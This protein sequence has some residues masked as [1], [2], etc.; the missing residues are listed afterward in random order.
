VARNKHPEETVRRILEI[1][2]QLFYKKGFE[3]TS[4][5]D[6]VNALGMSKGAIYHHFKSKE[7][8]LERI[9]DTFKGEEEWYHRILNDHSLTGLQKL[10]YFFYY[11][12]SNE[13]KQHR[14]QLYLLNIRDPQ[15]IAMSLEN[16]MNT[17]SVYLSAFLEEGRRDGSMSVKHPYETAQ[18][19]LLLCNF[20]LNPAMQKDGRENYRE[21]LCVMKEITDGLGVPFIDE[22]LLDLFVCYYDRLAAVRSEKGM[23][24]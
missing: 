8:I 18:V 19:L 7:E 11:A 16:S 3:K 22:R 12:L 15:V 24:E 17:A 9:G 14:D 1:S 21:K 4:I 23:P 2:S 13:E 6:I 20:W 5:Q 10:Y